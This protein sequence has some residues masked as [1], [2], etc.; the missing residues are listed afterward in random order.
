MNATTATDT[1]STTATYFTMETDEG[2]I[3]TLVFDSPDGRVNT[4]TRAAIENA[5][6]LGDGN[7]PLG[8]QAVRKLA[9]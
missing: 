7:G 5:P 6:G 9:D 3:T 2:G 8:H 4:F 1:E